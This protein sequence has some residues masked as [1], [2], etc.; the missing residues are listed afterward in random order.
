[1]KLWEIETYDQLIDLAIETSKERVTFEKRKEEAAE[2][3]TLQRFYVGYYEKLSSLTEKEKFFLLGTQNPRLS[4]DVNGK[5]IQYMNY[6]IGFV[7]NDSEF[8]DDIKA[9]TLPYQIFNYK[10]LTLTTNL[11]TTDY[12]IV[13]QKEDGDEIVYETIRL[14]LGS[15]ADAYIDRF[16]EYPGIYNLKDQ[17]SLFFLATGEFN[18]TTLDEYFP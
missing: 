6:I 14:F 16:I 17:L 5:I 11:P 15:D 1:M 7:H 2:E 3:E 12:M 10:T 13:V 18:D 8:L 4:V 9:S